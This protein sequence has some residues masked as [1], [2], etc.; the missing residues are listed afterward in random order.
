MYE[1]DTSSYQEITDS[2]LCELPDPKFLG[3]TGLTRTGYYYMIWESSGHKYKVL[4]KF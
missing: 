2:E 1:K 3:Q 4:T